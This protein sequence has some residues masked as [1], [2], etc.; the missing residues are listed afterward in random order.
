V[1]AFSESGLLPV[2]APA[3]QSRRSLWTWLISI[4]LAAVL[5]YFSLRKVDWREVWR[6]VSGCHLS[7]LFL[8]LGIGLLAYLV[9]A[10]RW[11]ILLN[12]RETVSFPDV[13]WANSAGYLG[14][15]WLPARAGELVRTAMISSRSRL[16]RSYV[17]TTAVTERVADMLV[18]VLIG[19][20]V[21]LGLGQKPL[22]L[23]RLSALAAAGAVLGTI[24]LAILPILHGAADAIVARLPVAVPLRQRLNGMTANAISAM[25]GFR[26]PS[27]FLQFIALTIL[28]WL[29]DASSSMAVARALHLRLSLSLAL[30]LL[31]ALG[32]GSALP[33]TPGAVGIVQ[34]VAVTVL[35][36]F[37]FTHS[38][39]IAFILTSQAAGYIVIT[40]LGLL[41]LWQYRMRAQKKSS[42]S[43]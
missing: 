10:F 37:H 25:H 27:R 31:T 43:P 35:V 11:R 20:F 15:F 14:N 38:D 30:L 21:G 8:S 19:S 29:I 42:S 40:S 28:I 41:G 34:F 18:L 12:A 16:S 5:L 6:L 13:L 23:A 2:E 36:P 7:F 39:A 9:R 17:L 22:W 1:A 32:V 3:G 24:F 4:P 26:N 33:S